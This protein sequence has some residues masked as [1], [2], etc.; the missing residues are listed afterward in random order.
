M[1]DRYTSFANSGAG[2][3]IVNRLGLPNPPQLRRHQ[4]GDP[5]ATGPVVVGGG[6]GLAATVLRML[7]EAQVAVLTDAPPADVRLAGLVYDASGITSSPRLHDLYD[8]FHPL[9]RSLHSCGRVVVLGRPPEECDKPAGATAQTALEGFIRSVG[10]EFG[11]G[12]TAQLVYVASGAESNMESTLRFLLSPKSAYVSGQVIR[13]S[14]SAPVRPE[15]WARPLAGKVAVVTGAA[16][17]IGEAIATVLGRDGA[18]VVC[19]DVPAAGD[20]LA[21]VANAVRGEAI[22]IDLTTDQAPH[23]LAEHLASRH[24]GVDIV[25]HNAGITRDKTLGRMDEAQWDTVLVG[26]SR[27]AGARQ[28]GPPRRQAHPSRWAHRGRLLRQRDRGQPRTDQLRD[29]QGGRH[30]AGTI[31]GPRRSEMEHHSER[32]S[33][34]VH[35]DRHDRANAGDDP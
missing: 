17:G 20:A 25:V 9:A 12:I 14:P 8:F 26:K 34:R 15:D 28:R 16:R 30:R 19:L 2:R 22:Q 35:R 13:V 32:G 11:R 7:G 5:V 24:G 33:T 6:D 21:S 29:E 10:K 1:T 31:A 27:R 4:P 3:A 18:H 23:V